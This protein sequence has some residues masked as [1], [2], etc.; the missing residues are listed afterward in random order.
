M[1]SPSPLYLTC[2]SA[3][4]CPE[5]K[6]GLMVAVCRRS[7]GRR[8]LCGGRWILVYSVTLDIAGLVFEVGC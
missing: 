2:V 7:G 8:F 6:I 1:M 4:S 5:S 3:R